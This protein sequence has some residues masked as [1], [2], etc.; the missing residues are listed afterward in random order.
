MRKIKLVI[1]VQNG[2]VQAIGFEG[3]A[4]VA[5]DAQVI[6]YDCPVGMQAIAVEQSDGSSSQAGVYRVDVGRSFGAVERIHKAA[7][8]VQHDEHVRSDK[9][10]TVV[11]IRAQESES[12]G[13]GAPMEFYGDYDSLPRVR[14]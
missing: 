5:F 10:P 6:D 13:G 7:R 9:A 12:D 2:V 3:D 14:A 1:A 8:S 4:A 11:P